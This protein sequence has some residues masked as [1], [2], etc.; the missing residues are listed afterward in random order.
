MLTRQQV[1]NL[2]SDYTIAANHENGLF[3]PQR[4]PPLMDQVGAR[5]NVYGDALSIFVQAQHCF[6]EDDNDTKSRG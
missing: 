3:R 4:T 5:H 1:A 6:D 2:R